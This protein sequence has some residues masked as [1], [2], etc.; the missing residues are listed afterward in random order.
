VT[1]SEGDPRQSH[2]WSPDARLAVLV[3]RRVAAQ[4][5]AIVGPSKRSKGVSLGPCVLARPR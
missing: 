1:V 5:E 2:S 4:K 3:E